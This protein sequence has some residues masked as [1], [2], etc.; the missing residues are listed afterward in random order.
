MSEDPGTE[1][2]SR[3]QPA[4]DPTGTGPDSD[5]WS[6]AGGG[7]DR[8]GRD[9]NF[10]RRPGGSPDPSPSPSASVSL[11]AEPSAPITPPPS[12]IARP[13]I[14]SGIG[15]DW[16]TV[17]TFFS[18]K[19]ER[20]DGGWLRLGGRGSRGCGGLRGVPRHRDLRR[21]DLGLDRWPDMG[22]GLRRRG[23]W[24]CPHPRRLRTWRPGRHRT[25]EAK[26]NTQI[27]VVVS[28]MGREWT[29]VRGTHRSRPKGYRY[30]TVGGGRCSS[31]SAR[32]ASPVGPRVPRCGPLSTAEA[33]RRRSSH[34]RT[35]L[36][37]RS[38]QAAWVGWGWARWITPAA[39]T[40]AAIPFPA[41]WVLRWRLLDQARTDLPLPETAGGGPRT[42]LP[43][44]SRVGVP[45]GRLRGVPGE[46]SRGRTDRRA[47]PAGAWPMG[48]GS[49]RR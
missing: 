33:G 31:P 21:K 40:G 45:G 19:G 6:L 7:S 30:P 22:R 39:A 4:R 29:R 9:R 36:F 37:M 27:R 20:R 43:S 47:S 28:P 46:R 13:S 8:R 23:G 5:W 44:S 42:R 38:S 10:R 48:R 1:L 2:R 18:V 24:Q 17:A 16:E 15:V 14:G 35:G 25:G 3:P 41:S 11:S 49:P 34:R 32:S 26:A 12:A